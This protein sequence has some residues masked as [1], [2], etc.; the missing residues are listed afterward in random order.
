[1]RI[2]KLLLPIML[3]GL[4]SCSTKGETSTLKGFDID[5]AKE[6]GKELGVE[7][8]FEEIVWE[9]KEL[10]LSSKNIDLI[11][12][13]LTISD[14]RKENLEISNPYLINKQVIISKDIESL[15]KNNSYKV[16]YE[17]GSA[18]ESLFSSNELFQ[19]S[20]NIES[21]S[22]TDA[23]TEV[24]SGQSDLAIIDSIMAGY[25]LN[26]NSSFNTLNILDY[27]TE[28]E[29]YGIA[30]RKGDKALINKVNEI[31]N[32]LYTSGKTLEVANKYGLSDSLINSNYTSVE[33]NDD[34]L[35]YILNKKTLVIGYTI[36]API[37]YID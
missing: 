3:L 33:S 9:Q 36:F 31:L 37:A 6:L 26:S 34:S 15:D 5:L 17:A 12:N 29:Y 1:M 25:Y 18:G 10:E 16:A 8:K 30:A 2:K 27:K 19:S 20:T 13:G 21:N 28:E 11:W 7:V 14:E 23:L 22:Q 32:V 24:L 35:D 4:A